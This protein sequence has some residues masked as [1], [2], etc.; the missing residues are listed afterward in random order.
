MEISIPVWVLKS[1]SYIT[2]KKSIWEPARRIY[3]DL[4]A[5][6]FNDVAFATDSAILGICIFKQYSWGSKGQFYIDI[7]KVKDAIKNKRLYDKVLIEVEPS[8]ENEELHVREVFPKQIKT[9]IA[10][11]NP[12]LL[13]KLMKTAKVIAKY[14]GKETGVPYIYH[15]GYQAAYVVFPNLKNFIGLIMPVRFFKPLVIPLW[16]EDYT[17]YLPKIIEENN[18]EVKNDD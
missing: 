1:L 5:A 17:G 13:T 7:D 2:N 14:E 11:Y 18:K 12:E 8:S 15:N 3:F 16:L 4:G 10:W 9:E 6:S